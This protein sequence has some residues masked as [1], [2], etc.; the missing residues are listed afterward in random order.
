MRKKTDLDS[1]CSLSTET[2]PLEMCHV[3]RASG[4]FKSMC[5]VGQRK[6]DGHFRVNLQP[7]NKD[8]TTQC[9]EGHLRFN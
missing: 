4:T 2:T 7:V 8:Y 1:T 9:V 5:Y 6:T 3:G